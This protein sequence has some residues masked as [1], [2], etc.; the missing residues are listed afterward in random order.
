[1]GVIGFNFEKGGF[2]YA[3]LSGDRSQPI[4]VDKAKEPCLSSGDISELVD[5][6]ES[7]LE[8]LIDANNPDRIGV[9]LQMG[10]GMKQDMIRYWYYPVGILHL[11][12]HRNQIPVGEFN[13]N[14]FTSLSLGLSKDIDKFK[15]LDKIFPD[16]E[17]P[18]DNSQKYA[19]YAALSTFE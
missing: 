1:M 16:A 14:S 11:I 4:L 7:R 8:N 10:Q 2:R 3:I 13:S 17:P 12:A 19:V 15:D 9:R 5:W 6:Y 18:W